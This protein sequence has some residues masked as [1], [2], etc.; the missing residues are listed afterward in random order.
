VYLTTLD[1]TLYCFRADEPVVFQ[2]AVAKGRVYVA[3]STGSL[4]C[5]ETGDR[6]DDGWLM[7]GATPAHNG[8]LTP[9]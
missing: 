3:T 6:G 8:L 2:P 7:W 5:I 1:G 4:F 9:E